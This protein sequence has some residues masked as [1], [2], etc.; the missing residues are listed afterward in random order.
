[1][2]G[3]KNEKVKTRQPVTGY[4]FAA[5][6]LRDWMA[7]RPSAIQVAKSPAPKRHPGNGIGFDGSL[8]PFKAVLFAEFRWS[9]EGAVE[10]NGKF[11]ILASCCFS[12]GEASTVRWLESVY[13]WSNCKRTT[14]PRRSTNT[15]NTQYSPRRWP[16]EKIVKTKSVIQ[17]SSLGESDS[18][19][20]HRKR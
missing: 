10:R 3:D 2:C 1:M 17:W 11:S 18:L 13:H 8:S 19:K 9:S 7:E 5:E 4:K 15:G 12:S 6:S 20:R 14:R 16:L